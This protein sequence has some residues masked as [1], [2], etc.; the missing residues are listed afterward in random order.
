MS[1]MQPKEEFIT[2]H[3]NKKLIKDF[4]YEVIYSQATVMHK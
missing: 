3:N 1:N 4:L 2:I